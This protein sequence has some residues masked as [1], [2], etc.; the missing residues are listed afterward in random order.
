MTSILSA[1]PCNPLKP[2]LFYQNKQ[3]LHIHF[4]SPKFFYHI[5]S[6][7]TLLS[8]QAEGPGKMTMSTNGS[9]VS[10]WCSG[11]NSPLFSQIKGRAGNLSRLLSKNG[12]WLT[13]PVMKQ[14]SNV[15]TLL[16]LKNLFADSPNRA[17]TMFANHL[18]HCHLLCTDVKGVGKC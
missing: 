3:A 2:E 14:R 7:F 9:K 18:F 1:F 12:V 10:T 17:M 16:L 13:V 6:T 8:L 4:P 15:S 11:I 5:A